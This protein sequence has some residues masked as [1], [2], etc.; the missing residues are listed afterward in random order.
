VKVFS[1]W[2][3]SCV[4]IALMGG[5]ACTVTIETV[6]VGNAGNAGDTRYPY[7][8]IPSFGSVA[9]TYNIGT[10][11][12][13]AAQYTEFLN[14]VAKTDTYGL[15]NGLMSNTSYGSGITR[16]GSSGS[17]TYNVAADFM[18]RPVN[19]MSWGDAARFANWLHNNQ[20]TGAQGLATTEDGAYFLNG[21]TSNAALLSVNRKSN[22]KWAITSENEW[23][24]AAY[25][26]GGSTNAGYWDYPTR[27]NTAPSRDMADQS[28]NNAN[29][30]YDAPPLDSG[31]YTTLVGEFQNSAS[32]YGTF[33]QGGNLWE[34][35]EAVLS[36]TYRGLRGGSFGSNINYLSASDR[37][38]NFPAYEDAVLGF[39][40]VQVPEPATALLLLAAIPLIRR[41]RT[42]L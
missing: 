29:Y 35:N 19:W 4:A 11:E 36:G 28:G 25:Y 5:T 20:P 41:R 42:T 18:N 30:T 10:Y 15:Y 21:K 7:P 22:W 17:Y 27:S 34:W 24:K 8:G 12:V 1:T 6:P 39:R 2:I 32:P 14:A 33:D 31:K 3:S 38:N 13:T 26:K 9:Y 23:Y 37:Y 16:S 40:L